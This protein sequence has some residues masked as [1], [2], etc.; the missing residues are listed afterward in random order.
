MLLQRQGTPERI[1]SHLRL[2]G[3]GVGGSTGEKVE[4]RDT[5]VAQ[6]LSVCRQLTWVRRIPGSGDQDPH[7]APHKEPASPSVSLPLCLS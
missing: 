5:W 3:G 6:W 7:R 4:N 2:P 1:S